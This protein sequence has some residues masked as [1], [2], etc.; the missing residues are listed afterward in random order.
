MAYYD[1]QNNAYENFLSAFHSQNR[2]VIF[3]PALA[4]Q[5]NYAVWSISPMASGRLL[6]IG[7]N[8]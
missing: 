4:Q 7:C 8:G 3:V 2:N 5:D 6:P 1:G